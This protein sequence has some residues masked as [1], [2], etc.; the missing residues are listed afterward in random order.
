MSEDSKYEA[1]LAVRFDSDAGDDLSVRGYLRQLLLAV[2]DE[3]EGFNGKRPFGN[4][5]WEGDISQALAKVG[6]VDLGIPDE[7]LYYGN[8]TVKQYNMAHAFV[9]DLIL[10]VMRDPV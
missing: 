8:G 3:G 1:A 9:S 10:Y 7:D 2:W 4:S 5:G 6:I